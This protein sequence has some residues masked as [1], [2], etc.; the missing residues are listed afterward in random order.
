MQRFNLPYKNTKGLVTMNKESLQA[1]IDEKEA[2]LDQAKKER[3]ALNSGRTK[4][5]ANAD[6]SHKYVEA[7]KSELAVLHEMLAAIGN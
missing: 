1:Q 4:N 2:Q 6:L 3:D 5:H 7:L